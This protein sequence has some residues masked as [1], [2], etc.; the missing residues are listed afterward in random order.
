[1][2]WSFATVGII[3][4]GIIGV[5]IIFLF[6]SLTTTNEND[7][8]L[9]KE[10]AEAAMVDAIDIPYYRET[11]DLKIIREKFVENFTRRFA[12][13]T[14]FVSNEYTIK[15]YDI[16]ETPPKVSI[17]VGTDLGEFTIGGNTDEYSVANKLD[18]ILEYVGDSTYVSPGDAGYG[19]PY[20]LHSSYVNCGT[21]D[22]SPYIQ[23]YYAIASITN[24]S[25]NTQYSLKIPSEL[26]APNIKEVTI[27]S[28][29]YVSETIDQGKI[30]I[31]LI[32]NELHYNNVITNYM[33]SIN[34]F[35]TNVSG[36]SFEPYN[37]KESGNGSYKCDDI[38]NYYITIKGN[39]NGANK[40]IFK[41]AVTWAY[42]EYKFS[43]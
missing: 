32:Q 6:Q 23:E 12:E 37:C 7:Y 5:A 13:S 38:N 20:K 31:A 16:M 8:Y 11:G 18:A 43:N 4:L 24:G 19:N 3:L 15:S 9:L 41:Y 33:Q 39:A 30:G 35:A 42:K 26:I 22:C 2:K 17:I 34:D 1:M 10:I 28:V 27:E 29:Q 40:A 21:D 25:F 36:V 14:L